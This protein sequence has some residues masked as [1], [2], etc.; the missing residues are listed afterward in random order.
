MNGSDVFNSMTHDNEFLDRFHDERDE[1]LEESRVSALLSSAAL[2]RISFAGIRDFQ[3]Q[4]GG[5][6]LH[7]A[8]VCTEKAEI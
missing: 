6:T 4:D 2:V 8:T 3:S 7:G 1:C 5:K